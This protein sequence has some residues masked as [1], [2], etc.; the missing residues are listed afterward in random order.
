MAASLAET[1]RFILEAFAETGRSPSLDQIKDHL[2]LGSAEEAEAL[3][4]KLQEQGAVHRADGD[5]LITHAYPFSNEPT[6]HKVRLNAGVEVFSMCAVDALGIPFM[7][8]QDGKIAS[9][10]G[11]CSGEVD[12]TISSGKLTFASPDGLIVWFPSAQAGCVPATDLCPEIN[13]FCSEEHLAMWRSEQ[14]DH[15]GESLTLDQAVERGKLI[16][17]PLL[18]EGG[19]LEL[20]LRS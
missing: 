16:F 15:D 4:A 10:C 19:R 14:P 7:L 11:H 18:E 3:V 9:A 20:P 13:F 8:K 17:G 1:H 12:V 2:G 5:S 6:N